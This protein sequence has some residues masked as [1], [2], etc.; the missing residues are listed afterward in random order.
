MHFKEEYEIN[1]LLFNYTYLE[2]KHFVYTKN[3]A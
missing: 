2:G 3:E 1:I